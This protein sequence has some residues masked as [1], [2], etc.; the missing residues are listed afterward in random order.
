[1]LAGEQYNCHDPELVEMALAARRRVAEYSATDPGD[2][3]SG[4]R[5]LETIFGRVG[6][7]VHI[8]APFYADYGIHT[9]IGEDTF[10]NVNCVIIDDAPISI[11]AR[12]LIGPSVQ[13]V[14]AMHPLRVADRRTPQADVQAG[15]APWRTMTAPVAI[16]NDVWLGGGVTVLPGVTVGDRS[17]IGAGS[18]VTTN[19]PPDTLA[20]GTPAR[21][22][23]DLR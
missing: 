12:V 1:M 11:G 19:I 4:R 13:L 2:S 17:T 5:I 15:S 16:G 6:A 7:R 14:T 22:V 8:E 18:I 23:R 21:P 3:E 9:V 20:L 10:I